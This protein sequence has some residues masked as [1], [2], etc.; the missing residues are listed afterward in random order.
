VT[1][2]ERALQSMYANLEANTGRSMADWAAIARATGVDRHAELVAHLKGEY[3]LSYGYANQIALV[4]RRAA[5][6]PPASGDPI[7]AV[8]G[9]AKAALRPIHD[10]IVEIARSFGED[11]EVAPKQTTISLRRHRQFACITPSSGRRIE[12]GIQLKGAAET[13]RLRSSKG[14]TSHAVAIAD[15]AD[16]DEQLIAWLRAAYEAS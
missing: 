2:P 5:A 7:D 11:V 6:G 12:L 13:A 9:G 15:L 8:F 10:R 1:D 4:A 14:M 3:G 16:V